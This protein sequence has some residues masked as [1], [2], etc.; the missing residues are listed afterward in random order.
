MTGIQWSVSLG[1]ALS[2]LFSGGVLY[3][4]YRF[5]F[6]TGH[7]EGLKE[8][9][10]QALALLLAFVLVLGLL[11][12]EYRVTPYDSMVHAFYG[13]ISDELASRFLGIFIIAA[14]T[15]IAGY[16]DGRSKRH[17]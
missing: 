14:A 6:H 10:W 13:H 7:E 16:L 3:L 2:W 9:S 17:T 8:Q 5:G 12:R 1:T 11:A 15:Y 4:V